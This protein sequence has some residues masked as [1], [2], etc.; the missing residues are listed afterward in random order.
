M[1]SDCGS[2]QAGK[3][4]NDTDSDEDNHMYGRIGSMNSVYSDL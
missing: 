3:E 4:K 1:L 2:D